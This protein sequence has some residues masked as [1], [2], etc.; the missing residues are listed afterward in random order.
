MF[1][2]LFS[3]AKVTTAVRKRPRRVL[4]IATYP[5]EVASTRFRITQFFPYLEKN[6][7]S[8]TLSPLLSANF[9]KEF[10]KKGALIR[11]GLKL[12]WFSL[13]RFWD[14]FRSL[15][16]DIAFVQRESHLMGP[17]I[18]EWIISRIMRR[19]IVFDFDDPV[20][21][22][23]VSPTYGK[24]GSYLKMPQKTGW[25]AKIS[26]HIIVCT[27]FSKAYAERY[28]PK[29]S[30][31]PTVVDAEKFVPKARQNPGELV[32]GWIGSFSSAYHLKTLTGVFE[33]LGEKYQFVLKIVGL[34]CDFPLKSPN[35]KV[36]N[37]EWDKEREVSDYQSLNIGLYPLFRDSWS[38]GKMGLKVIAYMAVGIPCVCSPIGDH[39]RFLKDGENGMLA[40]TEEE[41]IEKLSRLIEDEKL[42]HYL[43]KAARKTV[44]EWYCLQRQAP[45][46]LEILNSVAR[47]HSLP[48]RPSEISPSGKAV[49]QRGGNTADTKTSLCAE[50]A[51]S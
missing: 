51:G 29:V 35:V 45:R 22:S 33:K 21:V 32:I 16:Y 6:G 39:V 4:F 25:V 10:Y 14:V 40:S 18:V 15:G 34:G 36:L 5:E 41:W 1:Q 38:E 27:H 23:Y 8:C 7:I 48:L 30:V 49:S 42:R 37:L 3:P 26:S 9:C 19:P 2:H 43:G 28:N 50:S 31:I 13:R 12:F 46:L 17:P 44:E 24:I 20:F 47:G 11:K